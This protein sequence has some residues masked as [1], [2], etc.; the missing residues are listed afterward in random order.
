[1]RVELPSAS[2]GQSIL[3]EQSRTLIGRVVGIDLETDLAVVKVD[4]R[5]LPALAFGDSDELRAGQL[6]LAIGSPL[7]L[8]NSVSL[9]VVSA[10]A[11]QLDPE[12]PMIYVQ[13][14]ASINP[15]SSGGPLVDLRGRVMGLNTLNMSQSGGNQGLGLAAPSNIVRTVYEQIKKNSRVRRGDI[16]VRAQTITPVLAAGLKLGVDHGV[17]LADVLPG[18]PADRAGLRP[19]DLV[20][21]FEGKRMENGRQLRVGL[22]RHF[23]GEVVWLEV[24]RGGE[25]MRVPVAMSERRD[26]AADLTLPADPRQNLVTRLGVI[27]VNLDRRIAELLSVRRVSSGVV[28]A[29]TAAGVLDSK[30]GGLVPGDVI[31]AVN[32]SPV[33]G[34]ADLRAVLDGLRADDAVVLQVE[35]GGE[36]LYLSFTLE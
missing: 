13:T 28:V 33:A 15:G 32:R 30:E 21:S 25:T 36:L 24:L 10:V 34:L 19:G 17:V 5:K 29:S 4:E 2:N 9:G 7:G 11:R 23:V 14:D 1:V 31:Y 12:S 27:G 20:L 8:R 35:R 3:A 18:S 16:G 22:Y 6:V 26:L